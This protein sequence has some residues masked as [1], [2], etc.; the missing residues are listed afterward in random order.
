MAA[1][2]V[3]NYVYKRRFPLVP[4]FCLQVNSRRTRSIAWEWAQLSTRLKFM[5]YD[6]LF[7][8]PHRDTGSRRRSKNNL[9]GIRMGIGPI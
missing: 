9:R 8:K 6:W 3:S 5:T 4:P 2:S 7:G 1:Q